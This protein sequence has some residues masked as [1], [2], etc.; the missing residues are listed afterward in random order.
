VSLGQ[1][2][3]DVIG[4]PLAVGYIY[5]SELRQLCEVDCS[6]GRIRSDAQLFFSGM[7]YTYSDTR[8]ILNRVE[9][10]FVE[11]EDGSW[12]AVK[13]HQLYPV[14]CNLYMAMMMPAITSLSYHL[15]SITIKDSSGQPISDLSTIIL[16]DQEGKEVKEWSALVS[17]MKEFGG[18]VPDT[19]RTAR[20]GKTEKGFSL[21]DNL[22]HTSK[23]GWIA[24]G[25]IALLILLI[26][27]IVKLIR[28]LVRRHR[29]KSMQ[30]QQEA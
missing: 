1:G 17:Y 6:L 28:R 13:D 8:L 21:L 29:E 10:V 16:H 12:S 22:K 19:Y 4:Y 5:G 15:L 20:Q 18:T 25:V 26:I 27:G 24:Y 30:K 11:N 7:K 2:E 3:D 14:V 23:F 9:D